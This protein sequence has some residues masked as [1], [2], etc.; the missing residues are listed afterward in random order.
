[1]HFTDLSE[2]PADPEVNNLPDRAQVACLGLLSCCRGSV[3]SLV[4]NYLIE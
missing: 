1:M 4:S 3:L 2:L